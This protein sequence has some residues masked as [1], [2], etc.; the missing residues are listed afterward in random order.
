MTLES[1]DMLFFNITPT[2]MV[3][4][5]YEDRDKGR[6]GKE[7]D[8]TG[9]SNRDGCDTVCL[10][11]REAARLVW[12]MRQAGQGIA[13]TDREIVHGKLT[14]GL[15]DGT[16]SHAKGVFFLYGCRGTCTLGR[17]ELYLALCAICARAWRMFT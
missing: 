4:Q 17:H 3:L 15:A 16:S 2:G 12:A 14:V 6:D 8:D 9:G 10:N 13:P 7:G 5:M 1:G 11:G